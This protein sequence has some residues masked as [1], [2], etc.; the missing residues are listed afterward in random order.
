MPLE[1]A[2]DDL[3]VTAS[4][5]R[6]HNGSIPSIRGD[7]LN[8]A[9]PEDGEA[10]NA[11]DFEFDESQEFNDAIDGMSFLTLEPSKSGYTGPHSGIAALKVLRSLPSANSL[12]ET[13]EALVGP[14]GETAPNAHR[15]SDVGFG[16]TEMFI[17]DYFKFYH[18]SYPLLHEGTFRARLSGKSNS[19]FNR[20]I[21]NQRLQALW[22]NH[23]MDRGRYFTIWFSH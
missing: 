1:Q 21:F 10:D 17:D 15:K 14:R 20:S 6:S 19:V 4:S 23:E 11:D 7:D 8:A 22:Q 2:L 3:E 13:E 9:V 5:P 18:P 16:Y 12:E